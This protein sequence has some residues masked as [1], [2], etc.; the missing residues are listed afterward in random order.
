MWSL[1]GGL[2]L[3]VLPR[4][5]YALCRT[6]HSLCLFLFRRLL[7]TSLCWH[8]AFLLDA[9]ASCCYGRCSNC[10]R[11]CAFSWIRDTAKRFVPQLAT[12]TTCQGLYVPLKMNMEHLFSVV[13]HVTAHVICLVPAYCSCHIWMNG[14]FPRTYAR[15]CLTVDELLVGQRVHMD[16]SYGPVVLFHHWEVWWWNLT[17]TLHAFA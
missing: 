2:G 16:N 14:D 5:V 4:Y 13:K 17:V 15:S 8:T 12:Y 6:R 9:C 7:N 3:F 10:S 11:S 1:S